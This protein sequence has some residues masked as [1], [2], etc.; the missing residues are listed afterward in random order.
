LTYNVF[1]NQV[2]GKEDAGLG[3]KTVMPWIL[4]H[5]LIL[6]EESKSE[7]GSGIPGSI[8]FL[9]SAHDYLGPLGL[10][11]IENGQLLRL[12]IDKTV[13]CLGKVQGQK[14]LVD[15]LSKHLDQVHIYSDVLFPVR[16]NVHSTSLSDIHLFPI[17]IY[18][19]QALYCMYAHPSKK[20][21][22]KHLVDHGVSNVAFTW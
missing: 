5:K 1:I 10:C 18:S 16:L 17:L 2:E 11:T 22:L 20:S 12:V 9:C 13:R 4:L 3:V 8:E 7:N 15:H 14:S 6:F 21:K 19:S